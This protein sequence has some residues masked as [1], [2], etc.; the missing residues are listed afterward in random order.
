MH[1]HRRERL[2]AGPH[3]SSRRCRGPAISN[4]RRGGDSPRCPA[5]GE[6]QHDRD[7]G[8]QRQQVDRNHEVDDNERDG[9]PATTAVP[10]CGERRGREVLRSEARARCLSC[11]SRSQRTDQQRIRRAH[12]AHASAPAV[13]HILSCGTRAPFAGRQGDQCVTDVPEFR[14]EREFRIARASTASGRRPITIV[15]ERLV[16]PSRPC[17]EIRE[18]ARVRTRAR[19]QIG[20]K[21]RVYLCGRV[22]GPVSRGSGR[23]EI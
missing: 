18:S 12:N 10:K 17:P 4:P 11:C 16:E 7:L 3:P 13:S 5:G 15:S 19:N 20:R 21:V 8:R 1:D 6:G 22:V 9:Q 14:P 2:A 23:W